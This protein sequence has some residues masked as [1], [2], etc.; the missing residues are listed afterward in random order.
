MDV[1]ESISFVEANGTDLEVAR[2]RCILYGTAPEPKVLQPFLALQRADGGFPFRFE[3]GNPT[4]LN[5]TQVAL[6]WLD[7]LGL[8]DSPAAQRSFEVLLRTQREDGGWDEEAAISEY[9]PPPWAIPGEPSARVYLTAQSAFWLAA[10]GYRSQPGF[11]RA[12]DFL[13]DHQEESGKVQGFPH[14]TWIA[15][16]VFL[17]AGAPYAET[18]RKG[19]EVLAAKPFSEWVDSQIAWALDCLGRAG[20]SRNN[21]FVEAGLAEL[22]RRRSVEGKWRSEDGEGRTVGS[23]IE[24]LKVLKC[25]DRLA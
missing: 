15:T 4:A 19:L 7:E 20:L 23:I 11:P 3:P 13:L 25:Y 5:T 2:L 1:T 14:N 18:A 9:D 10:V 21:P 17:M 12:L 8:L 22:I 16:S 24:A 6:L